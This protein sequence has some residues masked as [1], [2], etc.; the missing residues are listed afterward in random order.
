M[1]IEYLLVLV[2][3][4]G[5]RFE[6]GDLN[7]SVM[8]K[9]TNQRF[10]Y[11]LN[12]TARGHV[13]IQLRHGHHDSRVSTLQQGLRA[14][15]QQPVITIHDER[16]SL[17]GIVVFCILIS[18]VVVVVETFLLVFVRLVRVHELGSSI[19]R[20]HVQ[21]RHLAPLVDVDEKVAQTPVVLMDQVNALRADVFKRLH[22]TSID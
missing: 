8:A 15:Q 20:Q 18:L 9:E 10:G 4:R 3:H 5:D 6:D 21:H 11:D 7:L 22:G 14:T 13:V 17:G 1:W 2:G 12:F 16:A 19:A